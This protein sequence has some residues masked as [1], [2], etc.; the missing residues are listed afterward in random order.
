P[1]G[2]GAAPAEDGGEEDCLTLDIW[3]G[4]GP[5]EPDGLRPVLFWIHGGA[6]LG[7]S[8]QDFDGTRLA[9]SGEILVVT[10]TSGLGPLGFASVDHLGPQFAGTANPALRDLAAALVWVRDNI[11]AFGGDPGRVTVGGQSSGAMLTATL[12]GTPA[13]AGL[14]HR[15]LLL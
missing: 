11:A 10:A 12:L 3:S 5:A 9:P 14:F 15:G 8:G 4:G 1:L 7:G 13:A 6:F 2:P